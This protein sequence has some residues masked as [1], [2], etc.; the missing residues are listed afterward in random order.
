MKEEDQNQHYSG[1]A[2]VITEKARCGKNE[3][4]ILGEVS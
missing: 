1:K 3:E 2:E 4:G